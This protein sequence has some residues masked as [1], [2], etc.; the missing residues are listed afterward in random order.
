MQDKKR[1]NKEPEDETTEY[2]RFFCRLYDVFG[3]GCFTVSRIIET[4][5]SNTAGIQDALPCGLK[6]RGCRGLNAALGR[7]F[8]LFSDGDVTFPAGAGRIRLV[9][10]GQGGHPKT[11]LWSLE[12]AGDEAE[13]APPPSGPSF[14]E[15]WMEMLGA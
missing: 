3:D 2:G 9:S 8:K 14:F 4:A 5:D 10:R 15:S 7:K 6:G 12:Y 13:P 11:R 1:L